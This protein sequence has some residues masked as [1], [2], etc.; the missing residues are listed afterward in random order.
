MDLSLPLIISFLA[1]ILSS[2]HGHING[3]TLEGFWFLV[4]GLWFLVHETENRKPQTRNQKPILHPTIRCPLLHCECVPPSRTSSDH[5][6]GIVES[7]RGHHKKKVVDG[8]D[9]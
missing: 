9:V 8:K 4:S 6:S 2:N 5:Q 7:Y 1:E 3:S